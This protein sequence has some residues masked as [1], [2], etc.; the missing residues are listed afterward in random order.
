MNKLLLA[1]IAAV[2]LY[3][4]LFQGRPVHHAPGVLAPAD[5]LQET[6]ANPQPFHFK[7][8]TI[9]PLATFDMTARVLSRENYRFDRLAG[10]SPMDLAMGWGPMSD[11]RVL[12]NFS[13]SQ[14]GRWY[15]WYTSDMPIPRRDIEIHSANMHMIPADALVKDTLSQ[16]R[17]GNVITLRGK[18]VH[19]D[20]PNGM[21]WQSSLT[22]E[23]TGD[24][25][26]E[27]IYVEGVYIVN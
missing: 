1:F 20:G 8:Y 7:D 19:V 21:T 27:V 23:D 6:I 10:L 22:R 11:S 17:P 14:S 18:L 5:P 25:S 26:C 3:V 13:I 4:F 2:L 16:V 9:T 15:Q 24:G 12:D